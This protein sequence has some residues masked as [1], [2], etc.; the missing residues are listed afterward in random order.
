LI[1][2]L[3]PRFQAHVPTSLHLKEACR[4]RPQSP[5]LLRGAR[6]HVATDPGARSTR[7]VLCVHVGDRHRRATE[8]RH[9]RRSRPARRRIGA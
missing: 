5:R 6:R 9:R 8:T 7:A 4:N 3:H 1:S 2:W